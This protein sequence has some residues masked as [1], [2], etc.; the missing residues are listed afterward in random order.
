MDIHIIYTK[1]G[2]LLSKKHYDSWR[3]IQ[4]EYEHFKTSLGPWNV[5]EVISYL[6]DDYSDLEPNAKEQ[7][8]RFVNGPA[9]TQTITF[10]VISN[11]TH[12]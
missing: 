1:D 9:I 6:S 7:V 11:D 5:D 3:Q 8:N 4:D 2:M 12:S 10:R